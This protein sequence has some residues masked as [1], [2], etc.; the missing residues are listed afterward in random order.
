[1]SKR[2]RLWNTATVKAMRISHSTLGLALGA[3][4][5][6]VCISGS[7]AVFYEDFERWEQPAI[8]E[9]QEY[10]GQSL[11]QAVDGYL[12]QLEAPPQTLYVVL[13]TETLPRIH[14][15]S[16]DEAGTSTEWYV[17][18]SGDL[19]AQPHAPWQEMVTNLHNHLLLPETVGLI[20]TGSLGAALCALIISGFLAHPSLIKDLFR[21]RKHSSSRLRQLD[22]HNRLA[23]WGLPF[24]LM[25]GV[26]GAFFGLVGVLAA[27]GAWLWYDNDRDALIADIYGPD[28]ELA[29]AGGTINYGRALQ[30]LAQ[31]E[32]DAKPIYLM[33]QN[34]DT[35]QQLL[36]VAATLPQ[37]LVYSEIYRFH[38]DGS[39]VGHQGLADGPGGRQVA[40]SAY[41]LHFGHFGG[42]WTKLIYLAMGIGLSLICATGIN[43]WLI[44]A[45]R[46]TWLAPL[47]SGFVYAVPGSLGV[48]ASGSLL[49]ASPILVFCS[50]LIM[51]TALFG[52]IRFSTL[53]RGWTTGILAAVT[54]AIP[55][56]HLLHFS[57]ME[58]P[59]A[60]IVINLSFA[61]L[62]IAL[63]LLTLRGFRPAREETVDL[64]VLDN[65]QTT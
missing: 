1:M 8:P 62:S 61:G 20:I 19:V 44:R 64:L 63:M 26:T 42:I 60:V 6:L 50:A 45:P 57:R 52:W 18:Q 54:A 2:L 12:Q 47:W 29:E 22:L 28:I 59:L 65:H 33:V 23:V 3:L 49:G 27:S 43:V 32:P 9:Y 24:H 16:L 34:I 51:L 46:A 14:L 55:A 37:R 5:Y 35:D 56:T 21:F 39:P 53:S 30:Q 15:A 4:L 31:I 10:D 58:F 40:Y 38:P 13:P 41:R 36:E 11:S 17:D 7:V 48:A 25:M